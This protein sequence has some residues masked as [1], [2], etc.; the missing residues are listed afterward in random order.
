MRNLVEKISDIQLHDHYLIQS[1]QYK[2]P[3]E[4]K[5]IQSD[6]FR[7]GVPKLLTEAEEWHIVP[8]FL[9]FQ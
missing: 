7:L 4:F 1:E 8:D 2:C 6:P 9:K 3:A 5:K